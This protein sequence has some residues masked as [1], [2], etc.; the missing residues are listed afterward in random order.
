L[1]VR[2]LLEKATRDRILGGVVSALSDPVKV[3]A[4]GVR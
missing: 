1:G 4:E 2:E 3:Q